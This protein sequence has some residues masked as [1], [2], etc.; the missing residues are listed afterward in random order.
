M[1]NLNN[2]LAKLETERPRTTERR[3]IVLD[4]GIYRERGQRIAEVEYK[5]IVSNPAYDVT[6]FEIV[7]T[8][9]PTRGE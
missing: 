4:G 2:R 8:D 7:R 5:A 3:L 9:K 6:L 1:S